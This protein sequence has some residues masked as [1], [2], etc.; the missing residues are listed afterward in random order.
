MPSRS[1]FWAGAPSRVTTVLAVISAGRLRG[2]DGEDRRR[3]LVEAVRHGIELAG[4]LGIGGEARQGAPAERR[5]VIGEAGGD[6][7]IGGGALGALVDHD[8]RAGAAILDEVGLV[9]GDQKVARRDGDEAFRRDARGQDLQELRL[10]AGVLVDADQ[11][12]ALGGD[13]EQAVVAEL[14]GLQAFG[15]DALLVGARVGD[16]AG[17]G[18][19]IFIGRRRNRRAPRRSSRRW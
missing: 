8:M 7:R 1:S 10:G 19:F 16:M 17:L 14:A 15:L 13:E 2:V 12:G 5:A 18:R 6:H 9:G 4:F 3:V 11:R